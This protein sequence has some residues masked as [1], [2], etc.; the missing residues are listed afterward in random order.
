MAARAF[1]AA[2]D[3][4]AA[5]SELHRAET[6]L[7]RRDE[8]PSLSYWYD[9][10]FLH[11]IRGQCLLQLHRPAE[12]LAIIEPSVTALDPATSVRN[13]AM[14]SVDLATAYTEQGEVEA[15]TQ[16]LAQAA[17]LATRNRSVRLA[18]KLSDAR[19]ALEPWNTTPAVAALDEEMAGL[20]VVAAPRPTSR[21]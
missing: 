8:R 3:Y 10:A 1:A 16:T 18:A 11:S 19:R 5:M 4:D 20:R 13:L 17:Q 7:A 6:A 2:G 21:L 12:A 14:T 15:A 9:D